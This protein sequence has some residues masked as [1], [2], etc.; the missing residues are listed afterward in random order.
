VRKAFP[1]TVGSL[2]LIGFWLPVIWQFIFDALIVWSVGDI[3]FKLILNQE[4]EEKDQ[5][6]IAHEYWRTGDSY[7]NFLI[8]IVILTALSAYASNLLIAWG[9]QWLIQNPNLAGVLY[10]DASGFKYY[11]S[12][13]AFYLALSIL[14]SL[15]AYADSR[16]KDRSSLHALWHRLRHKSQLEKA[17]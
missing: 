10:M 14:V 1:L 9:H 7:L 5:Y 6:E 4:K 16:V 17:H 3:L 11:T 13:L 15:L 2:T 8:L 12:Y